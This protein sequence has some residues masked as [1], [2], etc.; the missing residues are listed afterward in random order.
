MKSS[1]EEFLVVSREC[2]LWDEPAGG[3]HVG[4]TCL[5]RTFLSIES[6]ADV[7]QWQAL[8]ALHVLDQSIPSTMLPDRHYAGTVSSGRSYSAFVWVKSPQT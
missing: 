2:R 7:D 4:H 6:D 3:G 8:H 5:P 1:A